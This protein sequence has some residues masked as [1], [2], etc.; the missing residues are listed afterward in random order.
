MFRQ[1]REDAVPRPD[2]TLARGA[3]DPAVAPELGVDT[4]LATENFP[5]CCSP[6]RRRHGRGEWRPRCRRRPP[7][8]GI[9]PIAIA[10][11]RNFRLLAPLPP[12][13]S[14]STMATSTLG[15]PAFHLQA[16]H[17]R[18]I[19]AANDADIR[20]QVAQQRGQSPRPAG[21][22]RAARRSGRRY[23]SS[24]HQASGLRVLPRRRIAS[25]SGADAL[26]EVEQ[27]GDLLVGRIRSPV[28]TLQSSCR[29]STDLLPRRFSVLV[30]HHQ[31]RTRRTSCLYSMVWRTSAQPS[32][33][34]NS[35]YGR[36]HGEEMK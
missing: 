24:P 20:P 33:V 14:A 29:Y 1:R 13:I 15:L 3:P 18:H 34:F 31:Q 10:P 32:P 19:R 25:S 7:A 11:C 26:V 21:S 27:H 5:R 2:V 9:S 4:V 22:L 30:N 28:S 35:L 6:K 8:P 23:G 12:Q 16:V 17:S 36:Q